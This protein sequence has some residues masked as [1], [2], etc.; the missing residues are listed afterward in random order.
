MEN[1]LVICV[2][3]PMGDNALWRLCNVDCLSSGKTNTMQVDTFTPPSLLCFIN[4]NNV[5]IVVIALHRHFVW[6]PTARHALAGTWSHTNRSKIATRI[7]GSNITVVAMG[8]EIQA[9]LTTIL[10]AI[11]TVPFTSR[12]PITP[13][14]VEHSNRNN[15]HEVHN[16]VDPQRTQSI[17]TTVVVMQQVVVKARNARSNVHKNPTSPVTRNALAVSFILISCKSFK[18]KEVNLKKPKCSKLANGSA[19]NPLRDD[20]VIGQDLMAA[21]GIEVNFGAGHVRWDGSDMRIRTECDVHSE[22]RAPGAENQQDDI[23]A[24][25]GMDIRNR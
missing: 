20:I 11:S 8:K 12:L 9:S 6:V 25:A 21:L 5:S 4:V 24:P 22:A 15:L 23:E 13:M 16:Q 7:I 1:T 18:Q 2:N 14:R 19:L 10:A 17:S 3:S